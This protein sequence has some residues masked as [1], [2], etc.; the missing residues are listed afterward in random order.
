MLIL[1]K[2]IQRAGLQER[3]MNDPQFGLQL[4]IIAALVFVS[5][6]NVVNSFDKLCF[7]ILNQYDRDA[8]KVLHYLEDTYISRFRRNAP[9][10]PPL[11]PI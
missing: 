9:R 7:V 2:H 8:D 1:W 11:F 6:Q 10:R 3:C 5:S 4:R